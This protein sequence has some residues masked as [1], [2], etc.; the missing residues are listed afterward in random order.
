M[1]SKIWEFI[2][3]AVTVIFTVVVGLAMLIWI[4]FFNISCYWNAF[5]EPI[6]WVASGFEESEA[7]II[8]F[9]ENNPYQFK[10]K[11]GEVVVVIPTPK[12]YKKL[13]KD[14][15]RLRVFKGEHLREGQ[16]NIAFYLREEDYPIFMEDN[17]FDPEHVLIVKE[18]DNEMFSE[19][20]SNEFVE[21]FYQQFM[22]MPE[23]KL[24]E[25]IGESILGMI[26]EDDQERFK[27]VADVDIKVHR[28]M[29]NEAMFYITGVVTISSSTTM[30]ATYNTT[31]AFLNA[32]GGL[33]VL[34]SSIPEITGKQEGETL[35]NSWAEEIYNLNK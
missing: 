28:E 4:L 21:D 15:Y 34:Y 26:D 14:T 11:F 30:I 33:V 2:T 3:S 29:I 8:K 12:G 25:I 9:N 18:I 19:K 10:H 17:S 22:Q 16:N 20:I 23:E 31:Q 32:Q 7:D 5:S 13:S 35:I 27:D 6:K 24:Q 1:F